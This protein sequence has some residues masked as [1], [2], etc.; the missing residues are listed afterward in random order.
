MFSEKRFFISS[1]S[2][3]YSDLRESFLHLFTLSYCHYER[4]DPSSCPCYFELVDGT[5]ASTPAVAGMFS[6]IN[7]V[8]LGSGQPPLG[9]LNPALYQMAS[10]SPSAFHDIVEGENNCAGNS[11]SW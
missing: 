9:F 6:L 10:S 1:I 2:I 3:Y 4:A 11:G 5:S 8:L 7:E